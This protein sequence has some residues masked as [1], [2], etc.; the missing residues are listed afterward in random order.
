M[1]QGSNKNDPPGHTRE[2]I[3]EKAYTE[4]FPI[5]FRLALRLCNGN[6]ATASELVQNTF[7][8]IIIRSVDLALIA[9]PLGYLITVLKR[10]WIDEGRH[11]RRE[12]E[13]NA[14]SLDTEG[15]TKKFVPSVQPAALRKFDNDGLEEKVKRA[16]K[17]LD[18][19]QKTL[20]EL[21]LKGLSCKEIARATNLDLEVVKQELNSVR[22]KIRYQLKKDN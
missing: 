10:R 9:N 2:E 18:P 17:R 8:N 4:F 14:Y 21:H 3:F 13:S 22:Q 11:T 20:L 1:K 6:H 7:L 19:E 5:L 16:S 15:S 12:R